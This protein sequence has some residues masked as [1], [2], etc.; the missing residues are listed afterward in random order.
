[1]SK[2]SEN[3]K[4]HILSGEIVVDVTKFGKVTPITAAQVVSLILLTNRAEAYDGAPGGP[5]VYTDCSSAPL[6]NPYPCA[7]A[8]CTDC[9]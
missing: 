2:N 1:L 6:P 3:S 9:G 5:C 4:E 8:N 7:C